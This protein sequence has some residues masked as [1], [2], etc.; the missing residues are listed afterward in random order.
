MYSAGVEIL[1]MILAVA[2]WLGVMVA[3]GLPMWRVAAY[4]GQ[5]IVISQVIWEG[6]WMD[7]SVQSTGQ[8]HC[9][10]HDSLLGLPVDLQAARALVIVSMVLCIVGICLSVAGA[11]CTNCSRDVNSKPKLV[12]AAGVTFVVAGLLLLVAVSWTAHAIVLGFYDPLLEETA[13][14]EFGNALY[15]GWAASCLLILGGVL[16]CCSCPHRRSTTAPSGGSSVPPR[17]DYAAVKTMSANGYTRR[18]YV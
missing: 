3:C 5:N 12:V 1:G 18:D 17:V 2:G 11:K 13:K 4:I 16:L 7:C 9:K 14:R 15:F 10:V 8:M 6:L